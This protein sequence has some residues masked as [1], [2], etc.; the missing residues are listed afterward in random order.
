MLLWCLLKIDGLLLLKTY[1]SK[2]NKSFCQPIFLRFY[3]LFLLL[4]HMTHY[5]CNQRLE[6]NS[7]LVLR[8][9]SSH[10]IQGGDEGQLSRAFADQMKKLPNVRYF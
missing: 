3:S 2:E 8:K 5:W 4:R 10:T 9:F 6:S 7:I 1:S